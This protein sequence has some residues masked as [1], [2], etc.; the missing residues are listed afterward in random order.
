MHSGVLDSSAFCDGGMLAADATGIAY[1]S[2]SRGGRARILAKGPRAAG[3]ISKIVGERADIAI[4]DRRKMDAARSLEHL[5]DYL[6]SGETIYD[7]S[8]VGMRAAAILSL[9]RAVAASRKVRFRLALYDARHRKIVFV[10]HRPA[11]GLAQVNAVLR[12]AQHVFRALVSELDFGEGFSPAVAFIFTRPRGQFVPVD[13]RSASRLWRNR[14]VQKAKRLVAFSAGAAT[15]MSHTAVYANENNVVGQVSGFGGV[16]QGDGGGGGEFVLGV[17]GDDIGFQAEGAIADIDG[18]TTGEVA[19]HIYHRDPESG[20]IGITGRWNDLGS[21]E[22]WQVGVEAERYFDNVTLVGEVGFEDSTSRSGD[23]YGLAGLG[24]YPS[25]NSSLYVIGGYTLGEGV[26]QGSFEVQPAADALPGL[27]IFADGGIGVSG[28]GF[29]SVG[30]RFTFGKP[31]SLIDRDRSQLVR[32]K[33]N[34]MALDSSS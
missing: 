3:R 15:A 31:A 8:G 29:A 25:P 10:L 27:S 19:A 5:V 7:P 9:T 2:R 16:S 6:G 4:V 26:V 12:E 11:G 21:L 34:P 18:T 13:R 30:V 20:L 32:R 1:A 24:I 28:D 22:R 17:P 23:I 14:I 33:L